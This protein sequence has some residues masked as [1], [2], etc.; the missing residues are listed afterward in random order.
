MPSRNKL[1]A[2]GSPIIRLLNWPGRAIERFGWRFCKVNRCE[3]EG[4]NIV[5]HKGL[6]TARTIASLE[7]KRWAVHPEMGFDVVTIELQSGEI[8]RWIDKYNDVLEGLRKLAATKETSA[9]E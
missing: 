2:L 7:I 4:R 8:V 9:S 3:I 1:R 5:L 6:F